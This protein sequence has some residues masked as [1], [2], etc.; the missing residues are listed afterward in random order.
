MKNTKTGEK[1]NYRWV[2]AAVSFL[3]V[4]TVL[5]FCSSSKSLYI[6]A[7]TEALGISRSAFSV[8]DSCR[9][10]TTA[11]I[12]IFFGAL[13]ARFGTKKLIGAGFLCLIISSVLYS[14]AENVFVFYIGGVFLGLGL[15]WTTTTMVG[16]VIGR[17]FKEKRGTV[18]GA[19][20]ASNGLGAALAMQILSPIIYEEG[21]PFGYRNAYR[22]VAVLL[23]VVAILVLIF[24]KDAPS[25][26]NKTETVHSGKKKRGRVWVGIPYT[27][28]VKKAYFYAALTCI[29]LTGLVLQGI[30]GISAPLLR[31][32]G[33]DETYVATVLSAH[34]LALT[35]FK[36]LVGFLYDKAGLR[37][38]ATP[39]FIMAAVVMFCL[40]N[41]TA[42]PMGKVLAMFYGVFSSFALP[43]ETIML[44]I[45]AGD[46]FG[47]KSYNKILGL[48][49]SFNTA[50]YA[51][52]SPITNLCYDLTGNYNLAIYTGCGLILIVCVIMQFVITAA[53][54]E[55]A[56]IEQA[57]I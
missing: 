50:G 14:V 33:L 46:L 41:V 27:D 57:Q 24:M 39:C 45:F 52:G 18:M 40:A 44:P 56:R 49:V 25:E 9:F 17:W 34:S 29:F 23:S 2:I 1:I 3:M 47:E 36:F 22:I 48:F 54:S 30:T 32:V 10:I 28:A 7:V 12:N 26:E 5:G 53:N 8:N 55:H 42:S 35:A 11:I 51:L 6:S 19:V 15:A 38:T 43:L 20:L 4:F 13:V 21:N 31:D 37:K 16:A